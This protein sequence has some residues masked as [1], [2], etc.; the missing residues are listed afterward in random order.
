[1]AEWEEIVSHLDLAEDVAADTLQILTTES[2]SL[3]QIRCG[4]VS[5][6]ELVEIGIPHD[7]IVA[8]KRKISEIDEK[9]SSEA[10]LSQ[11]RFTVVSLRNN[12]RYA[13]EHGHCVQ[14]SNF[15]LFYKG[16]VVEGG[17]AE[18]PGGNNPSGEGPSNISGRIPGTGGKWLDFNIKPLVI[19]FR[20]PVTAD[21]YT[22]V[23]ANDYPIRDP[24]AWTLEFSEDGS[25]WQMMDR[26][27]AVDPPYD[28]FSSYPIF[29]IR[30][31]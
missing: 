24:V 31:S 19:K 3:N 14:I 23:T 26:R 1:M 7:V 11:L 25:S 12:D 13:H 27:D 16:N 5:D 2:V 29:P 22:L 18:N 21:S 15:I 4:V 8:L 10:T 28:R 20:N 30:G 6:E 9:K 17:K